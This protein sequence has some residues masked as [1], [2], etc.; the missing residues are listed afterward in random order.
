M[1]TGETDGRVN[2]AH[3]RKMIARLQAATSSG[4]PVYLSINAHAGHGIGSA[5]SIRVNQ[6]ADIYGFLFDQLGMK[7]TP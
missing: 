1:A 5:L 2:P 4:R 6:M 7:L 3:S